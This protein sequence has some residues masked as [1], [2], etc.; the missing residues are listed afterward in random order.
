MTEYPYRR[1]AICGRLEDDPVHEDNPLDP[2]PHHEFID[3]EEV[4]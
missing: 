4:D 1:C 2:L 3:I